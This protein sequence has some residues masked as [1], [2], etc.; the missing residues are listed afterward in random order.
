MH[1]TATDLVPVLG[2]WVVSMNYGYE[3]RVT[4]VHHWCPESEAWIA[5]QSVPV[6]DEQR[7]G[8]WVSVLVH[9]GGA[10]VQPISTVRVLGEGEHP[11]ALRNDYADM[12]FRS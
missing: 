4:E 7:K 5:G 10:V 8:R 3:G 2:D 11:D 9:G 12:Y 1:D 6:T